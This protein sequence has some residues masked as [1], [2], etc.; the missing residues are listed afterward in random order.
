MKSLECWARALTSK[1]CDFSDSG[2]RWLR[3][4]EKK[5]G[6]GVRGIR[7]EGKEVNLE[8]IP[9]PLMIPRH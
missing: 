8:I 9:A 1:E 6:N 2:F 7:G 3:N 4:G 5:M